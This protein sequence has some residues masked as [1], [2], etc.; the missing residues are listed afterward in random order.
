MRWLIWLFVAGASQVYG[1]CPKAD[2]P[3]LLSAGEVQLQLQTT[4][5]AGLAVV[6]LCD[7]TQSLR[8]PLMAADGQQRAQTLDG[9][10]HF[11]QRQSFVLYS[12]ALGEVWEISYDPHAADIPTG[13]IHD[14]QYREGAFSPGYLHPR[15]GKVSLTSLSPPKAIYSEHGI[16]WDDEQAQHFYHLDVRK[17]IPLPASIGPAP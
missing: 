17:L 7:A 15:R 3:V 8:W 9:A 6:W 13:K 4:D 11:A 5:D 14:F 12:A 2:V 1:Q 10:W 16:L